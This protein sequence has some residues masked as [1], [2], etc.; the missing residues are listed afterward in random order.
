[1][2]TL[3]LLLAGAVLTFSGCA[4]FAPNDNNGRGDA[5]NGARDSDG[6][7]LGSPVGAESG[8]DRTFRPPAE[9]GR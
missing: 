3:C 9:R 7:Y 2:K 4:W 1:M 5:P 8:S 6:R